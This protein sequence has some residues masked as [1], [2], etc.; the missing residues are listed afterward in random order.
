MNFD[1]AID[2]ADILSGKQW[3]A[4]LRG[5]RAPDGTSWIDDSSGCS[6]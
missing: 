3:Q 1:H 2:F 5:D 6:R 4:F